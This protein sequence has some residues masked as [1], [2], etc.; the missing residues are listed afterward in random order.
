[1][2]RVVPCAMRLCD[3]AVS[4]ECQL[5]QRLFIADTGESFCLPCL[6]GVLLVFCSG[7]ACRRALLSVNDGEWGVGCGVWDCARSFSSAEQLAPCLQ[8][9]M[10][11]AMWDLVC[12]FAD[13]YGIDGV[14][15]K[16]CPDGAVCLGGFHV[17]GRR[18]C[19]HRLHTGCP[20]HWEPRVAPGSCTQP[21]VPIR[22]T[23]YRGAFLGLC[24][25]ARAAP[26]F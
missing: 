18:Q 11:V 22:L 23:A 17:A 6:P 4:P 10:M 3:V 12:D 19:L 9:V 25:P 24:V 14:V 26:L 13:Q 2:Q 5:G 7:G 20:V 8:C 16:P 21:C 1:M 15:C